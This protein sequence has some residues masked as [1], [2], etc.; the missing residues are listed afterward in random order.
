[1]GGVE[2]KIRYA[3][4]DAKKDRNRISVAGASRP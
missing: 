3:K 1:M 4:E 2:G